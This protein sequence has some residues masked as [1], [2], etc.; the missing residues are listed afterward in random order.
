[1][2]VGFHRILFCCFC[3][4]LSMPAATRHI[5]T[6]GMSG[7][8][9]LI[10]NGDVQYAV[11]LVFDTAPGY[12]WSRYDEKRKGV[13]VEC[14]GDSV[15]GSPSVALTERNPFTR[16]EIANKSTKFALSGHRAIILLRV[17]NNWHFAAETVSATTIRV[18]A[19]RAL[20]EP[21]PRDQLRRVM[22]RMVPLL[23]LLA[24]AVG[25]VVAVGTYSRQ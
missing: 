17:D 4:A 18:S 22:R 19:V 15:V 10:G 9:Q 2:H 14:L 21:R 25:G 11:D 12:I 3:L 23:V 20:N 16:A 24:L 13:V 1:M 8:P 7:A 6:V 5:Y